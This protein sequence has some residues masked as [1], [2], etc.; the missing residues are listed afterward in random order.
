VDGSWQIPQYSHVKNGLLQ[1]VP[2]PSTRAEQGE[3]S[4]HYQRTSHRGTAACC[5]LCHAALQAAADKWCSAGS[6]RGK[7]LWPQPAPSPEVEPGHQ[8]DCSPLCEWKIPSQHSQA[9]VCRTHPPRTAEI[10]VNKASGAQPVEGEEGDT[11]TIRQASGSATGW[12]EA[13]VQRRGGCS[14]QFTGRS[15]Q[16]SLPYFSHR[17]EYLQRATQGSQPI[18]CSFTQRGMTMKDTSMGLSFLLLLGALGTG[19]KNPRPPLPTALC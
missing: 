3:E 14:P 4:F 1:T 8:F 13:G 18:Y 5:T 17:S 2:S 19:L 11:Q 6:S 15:Y 16:S 7:L 10:P 9:G 12:K